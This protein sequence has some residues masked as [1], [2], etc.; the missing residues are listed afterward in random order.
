MFLDKIY[1]PKSSALGDISVL[2]DSLRTLLHLSAPFLYV[3]KLF[4]LPPFP[5]TKKELQI[6]LLNS[7]S[8]PSWIASSLIA[9]LLEGTSLFAASIFSHM[10]Y[11]GS[12][13]WTL[14]PFLTNLLC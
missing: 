5:Q 12:K 11:A 1:A 13:I 2:P 7:L 10:L 8:S 4:L 6:Y 14:S 9:K 3:F